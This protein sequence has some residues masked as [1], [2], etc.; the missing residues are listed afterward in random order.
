NKIA[1]PPLR[2]N[3]FGYTAG[4]PLYIPNVVDGRNKTFFFFSEEFRRV[5]NYNASSVQVPT[6]EE[7]Q[8][9]FVNPVCTALSSDFSTCTDTGTRITNISPLAR[10]YIQDIFS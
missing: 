2:Y 3:D 10:A 6:L 4:G 5:I 1:R 9:S 7:R 8:G